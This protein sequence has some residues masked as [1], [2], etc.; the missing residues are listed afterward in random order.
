MAANE[1]MKDLLVL[2][3]NES[4]SLSL[5]TSHSTRNVGFNISSCVT[6]SMVTLQLCMHSTPLQKGEEIHNV[7]LALVVERIFGVHFSLQEIL[8]YKC[9][10]AGS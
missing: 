1:G 8:F 4:P 7:P 6:V 3:I 2:E 5:A 10:A 9:R